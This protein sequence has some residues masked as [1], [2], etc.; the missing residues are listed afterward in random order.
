MAAQAFNG[1]KLPLGIACRHTLWKGY[2][3]TRR[4]YS[5]AEHGWIGEETVD[6]RKN[7][8]KRKPPPKTAGKTH[9]SNKRMST[10]H[11]GKA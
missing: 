4:R 1:P 6:D 11:M 5:I 2:M 8:R 7:T 3:E 9:L 10:K